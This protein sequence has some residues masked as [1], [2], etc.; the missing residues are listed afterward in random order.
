MTDKP[1]TQFFQL[2]ERV[3]HIDEAEVAAVYDQLKPIT[4]ETLL[5]KWEGVSFDTGHPTHKLLLNFKW[6]GKDF[7]SVDDVD[8]IMGYTEDGQRVWNQEYGHASQLREVKYR[9]VVSTAM[10]YDNFPIIDSFRYVAGN[11]VMGA[12]DNKDL[13]GAGAYYFY[14]KKIA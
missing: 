4:P 5:G 2:T 1:E 6:A 3:G 12:M 10:I 14:L 9:G 11:V 8:P 13:K 7:R